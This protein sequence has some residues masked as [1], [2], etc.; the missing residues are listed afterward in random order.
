MFLCRLPSKAKAGLAE[1]KEAGAPKINPTSDLALQDSM[2]AG[3]G[4]IIVAVKKLSVAIAQ[5]FKIFGGENCT[6]AAT[7]FVKKMKSSIGKQCGDKDS[8]KDATF[9]FRL[10]DFGILKALT[11]KA[12]ADGSEEG[13]GRMNDLA[14]DSPKAHN[15]PE[16]SSSARRMLVEEEGDEAIVAAA[17]DKE[18][19]TNVEDPTQTVTF[20][21]VDADGNCTSTED[22][23]Y[24]AEADQYDDNG[25]LTAGGKT[26]PVV[27]DA[28]T[29]AASGKLL[30]VVFAMLVTYITL[31]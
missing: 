11:S 4:R 2:K 23:D 3:F 20:G 26:A 1:G 24:E 25:D 22:C 31:F 7:K 30:T 5:G 13:T 28:T 6:K 17:D 14:G 9:K 29:S 18:A 27:E 19:V 10:L 15:K 8:C 12:P 21:G 16:S